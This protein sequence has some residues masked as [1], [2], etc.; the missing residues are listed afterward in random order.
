MIISFFIYTDLTL[1]QRLKDPA[2][3]SSSV[4]DLYPKHKHLM[5]RRSYRC[6]VCIFSELVIKNIWN[7]KNLLIEQMH[8]L[9]STKETRIKNSSASK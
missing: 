3:I 5:V 6:K 4:K 8:V 7:V 9:N 2:M 1:E